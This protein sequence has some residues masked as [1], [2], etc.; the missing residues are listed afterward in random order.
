MV[1]DYR[2]FGCTCRLRDHSSLLLIVSTPEDIEL[3]TIESQRHKIWNIS[4]SSA[5]ARY[6]SYDC[7]PS[8]VIH[9]SSW[10]SSRSS[11]PGVSYRMFHN[12]T[13]G[14]SGLS[15]CV[16]HSVTLFTCSVSFTP[17]MEPEGWAVQF[18]ENR[19]RWER[20]STYGRK[21]ISVLS[22]PIV[23]IV[24]VNMWAWKERGNRGVEKTT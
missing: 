14:V 19:L 17:V 13:D 4:E 15:N 18:R 16:R 8:N 11:R 23:E 20:R 22:F 10:K 2:R 9:S 3:Q 12:R 5:A 24:W 1:V 6:L 7:V 21:L